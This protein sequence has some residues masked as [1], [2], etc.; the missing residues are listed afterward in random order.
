MTKQEVKPNVYEI[1]T[2][3]IIEALEKGVCPWRKPWACTG[4]AGRL[5]FNATTSKPYRGLNVFLLSMESVLKG[6]SDPRWLTFNQARNMGGTV[7]KGEKGTPI[8]F[9][10][11]IKKENEAEEIDSIPFLKYYTVFNASQVDGLSLPEL[12][13]PE[14]MSEFSI[15]ESAQAVLDE[16][17]RRPFTRLGGDRAFY[18][19]STD[20]VQLPKPSDFETPAHYYATAFHEYAHSTGHESRLGRH[21]RE[22][23]VSHRWGDKNYSREELVAEFTAAFLCAETGISA[24]TLEPSA[25]YIAGWLSRLKKDTRVVVLA[26]AAAQ[27]AADYILNKVE[28][29]N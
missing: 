6:Y 4:A 1:V 2:A 10:N 26:A 21:K 16:M 15:I 24:E 20:V 18:S 28:E 14:P 11:W 7:R 19:P 12:V 9:W 8:I 23:Y 13:K 3:R 5:P 22:E 17:P 25:S 29:E 27:K